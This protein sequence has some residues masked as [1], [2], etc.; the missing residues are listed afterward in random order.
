VATLPTPTP[1]K[2]RRPMESLFLSYRV[3]GLI[4]HSSTSQGLRRASIKRYPAV[5]ELVVVFHGSWKLCVQFDFFMLP[6]PPKMLKVPSSS[7]LV[8]EGRGKLTSP[9]RSSLLARHH[10]CIAGRAGGS[11]IAL[12]ARSNIPNASQKPSQPGQPRRSGP[13]GDPWYASV[14]K[15]LN[16]WSW[17]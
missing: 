8:Y 12:G 6:K 15:M 4:A 1:T 10:R 2:I 9:G 13:G 5:I 17:G 3:H 16:G 14:G 7:V 11:C